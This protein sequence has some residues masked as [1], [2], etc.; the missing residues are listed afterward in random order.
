MA[1]FAH[2]IYGI[3][4]LLVEQ[5]IKAAREDAK[6]QLIS[7]TDI[8]ERDNIHPVNKLVIAERLFNA[9]M[10]TQYNTATPF[11]GP[12]YR[13]MEIQHEKYLLLQELPF[14]HLL[15]TVLLFYRL[16]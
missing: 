8:G 12:I 10:T 11:C 7:S 3:W 2:G 5:Q 13:D 15:S 9:A 1:P 16:W 4:P 14:C 6:T